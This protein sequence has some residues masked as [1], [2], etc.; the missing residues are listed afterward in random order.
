MKKI[1]GISRGLPWLMLIGVSGLVA[2]CGGCGQSPILG[3]GSLAP[4]VSLVP[5]VPSNTALEDLF[6]A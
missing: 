6:A 2:A 3:A 1:N 4:V 5:V